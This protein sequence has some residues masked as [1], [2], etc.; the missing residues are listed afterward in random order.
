MPVGAAMQSA[1]P[2][3]IHVNDGFDGRAII[4]RQDAGRDRKRITVDQDPCSD[5]R[6]SDNSSDCDEIASFA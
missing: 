5:F 4:F 3:A 1:M 2:P 6:N